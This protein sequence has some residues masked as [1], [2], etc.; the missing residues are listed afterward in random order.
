MTPSQYL[1][2]HDLEDFFIDLEVLTDWEAEAAELADD[3]IKSSISRAGIKDAE[4]AQ[5]VLLQWL[6]RMSLK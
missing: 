2:T 6:A 3:A 1:K 5:V 4:V